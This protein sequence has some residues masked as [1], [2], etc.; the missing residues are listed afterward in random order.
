MTDYEIYSCSAF[1]VSFPELRFKS[2]K[3]TRGN[4]E[5]IPRYVSYGKRTAGI[6]CCYLL[7]K[8]TY[9]RHTPIASLSSGS[10]GDN[11]GSPSMFRPAFSSFLFLYHEALDTAAATLMVNLDAQ[12]CR[13]DERDSSKA[14]VRIVVTLNYLTRFP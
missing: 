3:A 7:R 2:L 4:L 9:R 11:L 6:G 14:C 13:H 1:A 10:L 5:A 12:N 8:P